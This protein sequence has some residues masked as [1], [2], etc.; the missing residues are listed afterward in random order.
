MLIARYWCRRW[1][2]FALVATVVVAL[3]FAGQ[4]GC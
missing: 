3:G 4:Y 1:P 2:L